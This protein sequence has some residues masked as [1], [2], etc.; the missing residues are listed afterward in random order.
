MDNLVD[1]ARAALSI[2][3]ARWNDIARRFPQELLGR[4]PLPGEWSAVECLQHLIDCE[5]F[6]FP[7]R[8]QAFLAGQAIADFDPETQGTKA[9]TTPTE[10]AGEFSKLRTA[11]LRLL[12]RVTL[13]DL[14]HSSVHSALGRVTLG[15]MINEWV[16][17]DLMH[18]VQAE[19]AVMQTFI[20]DCGAWRRFFTDH[21][22]EART[23]R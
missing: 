20:I 8:V 13:A 12:E 19:R 21:D 4:A 14:H 9:V 18:I 11:N 15:E 6:V 17:H 1:T 5:R 7:V 3:P 22:V 10:L 23:N 16:A 2:T